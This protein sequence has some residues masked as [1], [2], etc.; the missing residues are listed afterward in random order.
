MPIITVSTL[1]QLNGAIAFV[2]AQT[3]GS[4]TIELTADITEGTSALVASNGNLQNP[5]GSA[6]MAN[7]A[8]VPARN[9]LYAFNLASGVDV[10]LDGGNHTLDGAST[11][12]GLFVYAGHV[13]IQDLAIAHATA[14]GGAGGLGYYGGGGAGAGLGG[15]LFVG[16][17]VAGDA[18]VVTLSHVD[19]QSN[20]AI[21]GVSGFL[22]ELHSRRWR[23]RRPRWQ[24]EWK[25]G[26][27][28]WRRCRR[29]DGDRSRSC[30]RGRRW[31]SERFLQ[32]RR[33]WR[34]RERQRRRRLLYGRR[35]RLRWWRRRHRWRR[36]LWRRR[37]RRHWWKRWIWRRGRGDRFSF[38]SSGIGGFG[39]GNGG[40]QGGGAGLAAG[41]DIFVQ[42]GASLTI[43][44]GTFDDASISAES[45]TGR[46]AGHTYG[47]GLFIQGDTTVTL[48]A[49]QIANQT[50][51][52]NDDIADQNGAYASDHGGAQPTGS[53]A[54]GTP[55]AGVGTL[56]VSGANTVK[57]GGTNSYTGT[58][59]V[60]SGTLVVDGS[61]ANSATTV[62]SGATLNGH[63]TTGAVTVQ[64]GGHFAP[65]NSPGVMHTG[66]LS[67]AAGASFDEEIGGSAP[68]TTPGTGYDQTVVTGTVA[69][70]GATLNLQQYAAFISSA[71]QTFTIIDNDGTSDA[72]TGT[73]AGLAEGAT[74]TLAGQTLTI[75]Y[76]GGDGNDV[77]L[78]DPPDTTPPSVTIDVIAGND[79][80][81]AAEGAAT[82][83]VSGTAPGAEDGQVVTLALKTADGSLTLQTLTT[84]VSGGLWHIDLPPGA[85]PAFPDGQY[86]VTA[87]VSDAAGNPATEA[88]RT[89]TVDTHAPSAPTVAT[90]V[91]H[92]NHFDL[93]GGAEAGSTVG[94]SDSNGAVAAFSAIASGGGTYDAG[95]ASALIDGAHTLSVA[96]TDSAGNAS[97]PATA[98]VMVQTA[99]GVHLAF[100]DTSFTI[101]DDSALTGLILDGG[102]LTGTG[103]SHGNAIYSVETSAGSVN[104]L[105]GGNGYGSAG[106]GHR[107]RSSAG[108][109]GQRYLRHL[110]FRN[111]DCRQR[112][113]RSRLCL[114]RE[115]CPGQQR[116]CRCADR[117]RTW[118]YRHRTRNDS[119]QPLQRRKLGQR[120]QHADRR[121]RQ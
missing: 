75:S 79:V 12:R 27:R 80:V 112:R 120:R 86:L 119:D 43:A 62:Q 77:T 20:A 81:N 47:S 57:L 42:H 53:S 8:A 72:V 67:L 61:I 111:P 60:Q 17:N 34:R 35:R 50:L 64:S 49:G 13:A 1:D 7:G 21:G 29:R 25:C 11:Y 92:G 31:T 4:Y 91:D 5:D 114:W 38:D 2:D 41:G 74:V 51:T 37:R 103:N 58:T 87:D 115:L 14:Q 48:G 22:S 18:G 90:I 102:G 82:I 24:R 109:C 55:N 23:R 56:I 45:P 89:I 118:P 85:T 71:G 113:L 30:S 16:S 32:R 110:Q 28:R 117:G 68:A 96:A 3:S 104:T 6:A 76:H 99:S 65:G 66:N 70:N 83:T 88:T 98:H 59:T 116:W 97:I 19:F 33:R 100:S 10:T 40:T 63:G 46:R 26:R 44:G 105:I 9:D 121:L 73:F 95:S 54:D 107:R 93:L 106:R 36:W 52:I 94:V 78:T 69:L 84:T 15:G 108:R 39:A 101:G